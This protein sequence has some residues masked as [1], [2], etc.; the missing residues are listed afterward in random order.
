MTTIGGLT[1]VYRYT[2]HP[3]HPILTNQGRAYPLPHLT[4]RRIPRAGGSTRAIRIRERGT[5]WTY[6]L[7][8]REH[9]DG[10]RSMDLHVSRRSI[11][12]VGL[13][14]RYSGHLHE[15]R[16]YEPG[17][18]VPTNQYPRLQMV[19]YLVVRSHQ[20]TMPPNKW[21]IRVLHGAEDQTPTA[22]NRLSTLRTL[23]FRR[24]PRPTPSHLLW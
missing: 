11:S 22:N 8:S 4:Q 18:T 13:G 20:R 5:D 3:S 21:T 6:Q 2:K 10:I 19:F 14:Y 15:A 23:S 7:A 16:T 12:E 24:V 9:L 1:G 17:L